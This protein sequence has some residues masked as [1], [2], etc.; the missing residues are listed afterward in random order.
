[1]YLVENERFY[2]EAAGRGGR[3]ADEHREPEHSTKTKW[4]LKNNLLGKIFC[5][6]MLPTCAHTVENQKSSNFVVIRAFK[7]LGN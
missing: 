1:M 3:G 7:K 5:K 2:C 6:K 4:S